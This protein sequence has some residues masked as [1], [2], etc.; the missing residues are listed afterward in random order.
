MSDYSDA[1]SGDELDSSTE[2]G[3]FSS[4]PVHMLSPHPDC[5]K[6]D[7]SSGIERES[8]AHWQ[9]GSLCVQPSTADGGY[10]SDMDDEDEDEEEDNGIGRVHAQIANRDQTERFQGIEHAS[11]KTVPG[12]NLDKVGL[13]IAAADVSTKELAPHNHSDSVIPF[14]RNEVRLYNQGSGNK[15]HTTDVV[16]EDYS[17]VDSYDSKDTSEDENDLIAA[18][19]AAAV[20]F[21]VRHETRTHVQN[22]RL[23]LDS[24]LIGG[25]NQD[26]IALAKLY[27]IQRQYCDVNFHPKCVLCHSNSCKQT[28]FPCEHRC[29]CSNCFQNERFCDESTFNK[30][31][32]AG[33]SGGYHMCPLCAA[34][35]QRIYPF[36]GGKEIERYWSWVEEINPPLPPGFL[37]NFGRCEDVLRQIFIEG[38]QLRD[39]PAGCTPS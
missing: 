22:A 39:A 16:D 24:P 29:V 8:A 21:D 15:S 27:K 13:N 35:I 30:Q 20:L 17:D 1:S 32:V 14:Y 34:S 5:A 33:D 31:Q 6:Y 9:Q 38:E 36:D 37:R 23:H 2:Q 19:E 18:Y 26:Y 10:Y 4:F 25:R 12:L 28:F 11:L 3:A 7:V